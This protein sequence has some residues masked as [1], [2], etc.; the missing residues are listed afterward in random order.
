[1]GAV[2]LV[3]AGVGLEAVLSGGGGGL[4]SIESDVLHNRDVMGNG[5]GLGSEVVGE[6]DNGERELGVVRLFGGGGVVGRRVGVDNNEAV[7]RAAMGNN[8]V[9]Y[10]SVSAVGVA[11]F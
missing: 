7:Q 3:G 6:V 9:L 4:F 5:V 8:V 11:K 2:V 1:M 10:S